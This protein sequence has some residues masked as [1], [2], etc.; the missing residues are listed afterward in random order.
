MMVV[1]LIFLSLI[2]GFKSPITL[3]ALGM[4]VI[5][6]FVSGSL[7]WREEFAADRIAVQMGHQA[8]YDLLGGFKAAA[9]GGSVWVSHPSGKMRKKRMEQTLA[10]L[11]GLRPLAQSADLQHRRGVPDRAHLPDGQVHISREREVAVGREVTEV[12]GQGHRR[13]E[14]CKR[15]GVPS[16][17]KWM[18]PESAV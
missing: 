11:R 5:L 13:G 18:V 10:E 15:L 3:V 17:S 4:W 14:G 7:S 2:Y 8:G 12:C 1:Y 6:L 16:V 9:D